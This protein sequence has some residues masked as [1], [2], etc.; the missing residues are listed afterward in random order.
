MA[1]YLIGG[2]QA[3]TQWKFFVI[4]DKGAL[5][6]L[7]IYGEK[8]LTAPFDRAHWKLTPQTKIVKLEDNVTMKLENLGALSR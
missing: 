2:Y 5:V 8:G 6:V 4:E 3:R 7:R 1:S